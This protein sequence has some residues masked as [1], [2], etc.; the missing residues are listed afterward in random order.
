MYF[1]STT[2]RYSW[3]ATTFLFISLLLFGSLG[4]SAQGTRLLRQPSM[5]DSHITFA[6]GSDIWVANL[7]G[8]DV[9][10]MT[11]TPAMEMNPSLSPDGQQ[12]AFSS[13]RSGLVAVYVV[14]ITGGMP[15]RL[16]WHPAAAFVCGWTPDG[17]NVLY[18]TS[19]G[20]APKPSNR[21]WTIPVTGGN[22]SLLTAQR[23]IR[24]S[25]SPDGN[26]IA[27]D[28]VS[29]W[30]SE[31]RA[32]RG[33][34][35][36]P[37]VV[38]N[39]ADNSEVLIPNEGSMDLHPVWIGETIYFLSD[40]DWTMN[41]WAYTP[42]TKGLSQITN[43]KGSDIKW[44]SGKEELTFE[45]DG[46]LF[47]LDPTNTETTQLNINISGDFPWAETAW[48]EVGSR[49]RNARLSA[50]GK[51]A[52]VE[53]RGE[54]FTIP[55]EH[56]DARNITQ[57]SDAADRAP[58]WSPKGDQVAWF[59][60]AGQKGYALMIGDQDGLSAPKKIAIGASKMAWSPVW[61]PDGKY[62]A[63]IDDDVR[64]RMLE[65]E[66][67]EIQTI[68]VGGTNI[69]RG[70]MELAWSKDSKFLAYDKTGSNYFKS[71]WVWSAEDG[72]TRAITNSFANAFSPSWDLDGKHLY[73]LAS[74]DVGLSSGWANTSSMSARAEYAAYIVNLSKE[75]PSPFELRS[76]EEEAEA[77]EDKEEA[78]KE[79]SSDD[80]KKKKKKK[81][82]TAEKEE[83]VPNEEADA[84]KMHIDFDQID[85]RI[86]PLPIPQRSY[87][88]ILAGPEGTVF[89]GE[90]IANKPGLKVSKFTLK[91][92]ESKD[93]ASGVNYMTVSADRKKILARIN[94][95]WKIMDCAKPASTAKSIKM[96][97]QMKVNRAEEWQQMFEETWRYERDFFYDPNMHGRDW[98]VVY[99][100]YAPL[101]PFVKH[102]HDL[103]YIFDQ[104]NGELSVG[105]SFVS[106]GDYPEVTSAKIGLLGADLVA[107]N[108]RWKI[109]RIYTTENWNPNLTSPLDKPG[110]KIKPNYYIVGI[111]GRELSS[112]DN[113][114]EFLDGT[115][116]KQTILHLNST[117][118]FSTA[119]REVV[120][121]IS[122]RA[123]VALRQRAWVE[124][125]RRIVDSLS[126]GQL[127]YVWVPNT[128]GQGLVSFNRYYF[129][130]QDKKGAVIDERYNGG[131]L[132]D[133]YMVDLMTRRL[134]A[135][136]TNEVPNGKPSN[137]PA[138]ILGPKV[139]LINEMAGSGGDFFP[140]VF[141]QQQA[142][143]LIGTR[144]WGGLVKSSVHY[145]LVDGG[146]VTAPDNAIFD[147]IKGEWIGENIG[148]APDIEVRQDAKALA[149]GRDPQLERAVQELLKLLKAEEIE[150]KI[151]EYPTPAK[152]K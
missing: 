3:I 148:I 8:S 113:L 92:R 50:S 96:N 52:I 40:R 36:T 137:L 97:L 49:A 7:D 71:I 68:D 149:E 110:A 65:L 32:Y 48:E 72:Q 15:Q 46:Y 91:D 144:T 123:E 84:D 29:R 108:N 105:H 132:L 89:I 150:I 83:S 11:N 69:E 129:A 43:F 112:S 47:L 6:Y 124:D 128:S 66:T 51:R 82:Q 136:I 109:Q 41:I 125:N 142:G 115:L 53:A 21:L 138:G 94:G 26:R 59:S 121:P 37:L 33:G 1:L 64:I 98:Q 145:L 56:G 117:P 38:L 28:V 79:A 35:N 87:R 151:P 18:A 76:D 130:Q 25:F 135:S 101:I 104:I 139:L 127:A 152:Q 58:L 19:R 111:N 60:D 57:S 93:F 141:R 2:F 90:R 95:G 24:G 55:V 62:I 106:G 30:D 100:R 99:D 131:G 61:S 70:G 44:L 63:F 17:K 143:P 146:R 13:N 45:R 23:G 12:I 20:F 88:F 39:I 74:T 122:F 67:E 14:P 80:G 22:P 34:Q 147:P 42:A 102:R 107:E 78:L 120:K 134:R 73:F 54:I 103:N 114:F 86:I 31:W 126:N 4:L 16:T 119:W 133:D 81:K 140:W 116:R 10:R 118:E 77:E 85:R 5:S 27:I 75:D 9:R